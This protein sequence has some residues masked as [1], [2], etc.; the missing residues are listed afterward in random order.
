MSCFDWFVIN[1]QTHNEPYFI[2]LIK[3]LKESSYRI[4]PTHLQTSCSCSWR[5]ESP[6]TQCV[7]VNPSSDAAAARLQ[8]WDLLPHLA[9]QLET[10]CTPQCVSPELPGLISSSPTSTPQLSLP[11]CR[12]HK[13]TC[14]GTSPWF[15]ECMQGCN[16]P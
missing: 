1:D 2:I 11:R 7:L 10:L 5:H 15:S 13:S 16:P 6:S 14:H 12:D 3:Q 9:F 8:K 4:E